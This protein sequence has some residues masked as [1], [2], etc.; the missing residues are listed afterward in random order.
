MKC[1]LKCLLLYFEALRTSAAL[2]HLLLTSE[3]KYLT[4]INTIHLLNFFKSIIEWKHLLRKFEGCWS[5]KC[6]KTDS[7][8]SC[9]S[10]VHDLPTLYHSTMQWLH[11]MGSKNSIWRNMFMYALWNQWY[12]MCICEYQNYFMHKVYKSHTW[13]NIL[14]IAFYALPR[15]CAYIFMS[16]YVLYFQLLKYFNFLVIAY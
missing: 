9:N 4:A 1:V 7:R 12:E 11:L 2:D 3:N 16:M 8:C 13:V 6:I 14:L 15:A 10:L 5:A